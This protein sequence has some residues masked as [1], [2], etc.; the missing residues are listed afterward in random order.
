MGFITR[1]LIPRKVRRLAH[2]VRAAKRAI[3]PKP[4]KQ[5]INIVSIF[6]NPVSSGVYAVERSVFTKSKKRSAPART[7]Q[8]GCCVIKHRSKEAAMK[9]RK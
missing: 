4:L 9:C 8:H 7:Y 5:A 2:P 3:Y 1:R 6:R